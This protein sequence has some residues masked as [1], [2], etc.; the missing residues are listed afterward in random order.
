[1]TYDTRSAPARRPWTRDECLL[2]LDF[3]CRTPFGRLHAGNPDAVA[4]AQVLKRSP[5][6]VAM[7]AVNFASL[8][9]QQQQ[10]GI[11]GLKNIS[12]LDRQT[13]EE[14]LGAG[15]WL[16]FL[17][18]V[19]A[20]RHRLATQAGEQHAPYEPSAH[21]LPEE[22]EIW[23]EARVRRVQSFFRRTVLGSYD[24]CCAFCRLGDGRLLAASHIIPW[25][26]DETRRADP[27]NGLSLC[28]LH[29]RAFDR[30][31]MSV[32]DDLSILVSKQLLDKPQ[33]LEMHRVA[34][35]AIRGDRMTL[36]SRFAPDPA[37][38]AY[39]RRHRFEAERVS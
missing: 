24:M 26:A 38:L 27:R 32:G 8:D 2:V 25:A 29:D 22:T 14:F 6:A 3:Y 20:A 35:V 33:A 5:G 30:G 21:R 1:M 37:A 11:S 28:A 15:R 19:E 4:L 18:E 13:F 16:D 39:H 17:D 12:K 10:R 7:K 34:F 23:R 9:P 31:L 36:P